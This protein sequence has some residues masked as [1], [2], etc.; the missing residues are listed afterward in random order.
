LR[1]IEFLYRV[2]FFSTQ[3]FYGSIKSFEGC[4]LFRESI[5]KHAKFRAWYERMRVAVIK[6][7]EH[8]ETT[9]SSLILKK[10]PIGQLL[11]SIDES[12]LRQIESEKETSSA[13][14]SAST[15]PRQTPLLDLKFSQTP[16]SLSQAEVFRILSVNYLVNVVIFTYAAW[17]SR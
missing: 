10:K 4:A 11:K 12:T 2:C 13:S 16:Q 15:S 9:A 14:A 1:Q 5:A 8:N 7:N 17:M 6:R 3:S